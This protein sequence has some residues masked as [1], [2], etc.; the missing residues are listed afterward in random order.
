MNII[1][2]VTMDH[3]AVIPFAFHV[4]TF[5]AIAPQGPCFFMATSNSIESQSCLFVMVSISNNGWYNYY[6]RGMT[7]GMTMVSPAYSL[8]TSIESVPELFEMDTITNRQLCSSI[9]L[10]VAMKM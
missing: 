3:S 4:L 10:F 5:I 7:K 6:V 2:F 9:E 1:F 8:C